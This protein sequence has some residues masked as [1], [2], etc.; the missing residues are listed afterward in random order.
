MKSRSALPNVFH[1]V[2]FT[3]LQSSSKRLQLSGYC[4]VLSYEK[5]FAVL[6]YEKRLSYFSLLKLAALLVKLAQPL[7]VG[8]RY[9][10]IS[11]QKLE[12]NF[13]H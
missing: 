13:L 7:S 1:P 12:Q 10:H 9:L 8:G 5:D 2:S 11:G 6:A 3:Y 4:S